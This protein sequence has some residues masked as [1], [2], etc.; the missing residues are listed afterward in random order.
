M[1]VSMGLNILS[2]STPV[3]SYNSF[4]TGTYL[5]RAL[6]IFERLGTRGEPDKVRQVLAA[7]L[8]GEQSGSLNFACE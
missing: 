2:L 6:E 3:L 8:G 5:T 7:L 1:S 4:R